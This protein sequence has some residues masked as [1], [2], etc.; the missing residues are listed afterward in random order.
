LPIRVLALTSP[1]TL[2][3]VVT[4][5]KILPLAVTGACAWPSAVAWLWVLVWAVSAK[6]PVLSAATIAVDIKMRFMVILPFLGS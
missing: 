2:S 3:A 4:L 5:A 1:L 6:A